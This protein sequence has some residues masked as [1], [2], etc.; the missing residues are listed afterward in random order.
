MLHVVGTVADECAM[1]V[2]VDIVTATGPV[3]VSANTSDAAGMIFHQY[4][5]IYNVNI[6]TIDW[7]VCVS[8]RTFQLSSR[9]C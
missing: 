5:V 7:S 1:C 8:L 2:C 9:D 3:T 4:I 6:T